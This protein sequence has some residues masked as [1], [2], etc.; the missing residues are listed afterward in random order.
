MG[1]RRGEVPSKRHQ[2]GV[3]QMENLLQCERPDKEDL[4]VKY[5]AVPAR[6][7]V[8]AIPQ[9]MIDSMRSTFSQLHGFKKY[10][11]VDFRFFIK[12]VEDFRQGAPVTIHP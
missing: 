9:R 4:R 6:R 2:V 8:Q 10:F 5:A 11:S 1:A 12:T 7:C 3:H